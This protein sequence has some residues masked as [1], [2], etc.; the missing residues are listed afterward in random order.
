MIIMPSTPRLS[1]PERSATSSPA[2]ASSR[3]VDAAITD[4]M[5]A[6]AM[7]MGVGLGLGLGVPWRRADETDAM[8][9]Q[10]IAGKHVEQQDALEDLGKV[11]RDLERDLR[12]LAADEGEREKEASNQDADRIEPAEEGDDDRCEPVARRDARLQVADWAGDLDDAGKPGERARHREG[13]IHQLIAVEAG[14]ARRLGRGADDTDLEALQRAPE[15]DRRQHHQDQ[16]DDRA[17]M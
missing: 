10:G 3:G 11:E 4:R 12:A 16:R 6:S 2:A 8:D 7:S 15:Q 5:M 17:G 1:T 14:K 9:D 13:E